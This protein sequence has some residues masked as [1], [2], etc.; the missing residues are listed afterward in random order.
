MAYPTHLLTDD[1]EIVHEFHPHWRVLLVALMWLVV[2]IA[3]G[4]VVYLVDRSSGAADTGASSVTWGRWA[5]LGG[6]VIG[7]ASMIPALLRRYA[8]LYVLTTERMVVRSG[9]LSKSGVEIPLENINNVLFSQ[10]LW[11]RMLGYGDVL[12]E[13]AGAQGQ[14]R[15]T[16]IPDPVRFQS[17]VYRAREVRVMQ[18]EGGNRAVDPVDQLER[19]ADLRDRGAISEEEFEAKKRDLLGRL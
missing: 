18:L 14:S 4:V 19:L 8:R 3:A 2:W 9:I 7:L 16:D 17:E 6:I 11:E 1:E 12:I 10:S 13:S 5:L 15:L